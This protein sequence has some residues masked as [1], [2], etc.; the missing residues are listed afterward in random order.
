MLN[1]GL[2]GGIACGKSTVTRLFEKLGVPVIDADEI[3]HSLVLPQQPALALLEKAFG[4]QIITADGSLN[5]EALRELVFSSP[6]DKK[7]LEAILHPLIYQTMQQQLNH[8]KT[9]YVILSI[10]LLLESKQP[11]HIDRVLLID[12]PEDIQIQRVKSR[13]GFSEKMIKAIIK[14]QCPRNERLQHADDVINNTSTL[15][16]LVSEVSKLHE[17]YLKISTSKNP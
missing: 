8:C 16:N 10:P 13:N 3:A 7:K 4:S 6:S 9:P 15:K 17:S 2:T 12:C 14:S 1:I 11:L 5:R